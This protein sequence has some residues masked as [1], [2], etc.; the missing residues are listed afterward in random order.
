MATD[1]QDTALLAKISGGDLIPFEAKY[2]LTSLTELQIRH[3]SKK[4]RQFQESSESKNEE[5]D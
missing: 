4:T 3:R 5:V 1:L 2:H